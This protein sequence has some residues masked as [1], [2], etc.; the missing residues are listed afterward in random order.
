M[1]MVSEPGPVSIYPVCERGGIPGQVIKLARKLP[2]NV[3]A[4]FQR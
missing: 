1:V 4:I 2:S 3:T